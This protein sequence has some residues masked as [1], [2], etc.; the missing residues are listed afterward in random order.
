MNVDDPDAGNDPAPDLASEN[1]PETAPETQSESAGDPLPDPHDTAAWTARIDAI[2]DTVLLAAIQKDKRATSVIFAGFAVRRDSLARTIVRER[3]PK[4]I[5]R[6]PGFGKALVEAAAKAP[7]VK[8]SRSK[9]L[10][11]TLAHKPVPEAKHPPLP[12]TK[13]DSKA[14]EREKEHVKKLRARI[15][16][17]EKSLVESQKQQAA[18]DKKLV[19]ALATQEKLIKDAAK[20]KEFHERAT[21]KAAKATA[22]TQAKSAPVQPA[23]TAKATAT[24]APAV[25][26]V[27]D[28]AWTAAIESLLRG[29]KAEAATT[30]LRAF[31]VQDISLPRRAHTL[32][33]LSRTVLQTGDP[34]A[35]EDAAIEASGALAELGDLEGA[36]LHLVESLGPEIDA[37]RETRRSNLLVRI[38]KLF[39]RDRPEGALAAHL[40]RFRVRQPGHVERV[41]KWKAFQDAKWVKAWNASE[42][43]VEVAPLGRDEPVNLPSPDARLA[44]MTARGLAKAVETGDVAL[45]GAARSALETLAETRPEFE[46]RLLQA[47]RAIDPALAEPLMTVP[48]LAAVVDA[49]NVARH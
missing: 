4:F 22:A 6:Q 34:A 42:P 37:E 3:I 31:V 9:S 43:T 20:A 17:L 30:V 7:P 2:P 14:L 16:E 24:P 47:V 35:A 21:R 28:S 15:A 10:Q 46:A 27:D 39:T 13:A 48:I 11:P 41:R 33:L 38:F 45:V 40:R 5:A 25:A 32:R 44:T 23:T 49:S 19:A 29:G 12:E 26:I 36:L 8:P 18:T 1:T